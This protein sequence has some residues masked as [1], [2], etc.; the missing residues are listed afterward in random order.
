MLAPPLA[1]PGVD[2]SDRHSLGDIVEGH[3]EEEHGVFAEGAAAALRGVG[4][5]VLVRDNAVEEQQEQYSEQESRRRWNKSEPPQP[6]GLLHRGNEQAPYGGRR[7]DPRRESGEAPLNQE[8]RLS[9]Q[10]EYAGGSGCGADEGDKYAVDYLGLHSC[11]L[12]N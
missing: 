3:G 8:V 9:A 7:H 12:S 1:K 5:H 2:H 4:V 10:E 11:L 6:L